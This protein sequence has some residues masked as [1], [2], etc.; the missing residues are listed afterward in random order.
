[1]VKN[2]GLIVKEPT[3]F[4]SE[5]I[6]ELQELKGVLMELPKLLAEDKI[7]DS[8]PQLQ[9]TLEYPGT[10]QQLSLL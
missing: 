10:F 9:L 6:E 7:E 8:D 1:M 4:I 3:T 5:Q 2:D